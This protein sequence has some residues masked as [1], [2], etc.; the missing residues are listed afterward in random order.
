MDL[1]AAYLALGRQADAA[2]VYDDVLRRRPR[3]TGALKLAGDLARARGDVKTAATNYARLHVLAPHDPRPVF[4]MAAAYVQAGDLERAQRWFDEASQLPGMMGDAY[5][6]LGAIALRR[7]DA[8]QALWYLSRAVRRRPD[9]A[10]IRYNHAL[11]LHLLGRE[12]E[13]LD[14]LRV[15]A[16]A[17]PG[18]AGVRFFAGVVALALGKLD[19]ATDSFKAAVELD[20]GFDDARE[21]LA[22]LVERRPSPAP[23]DPLSVP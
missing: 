10:T 2:G 11:A 5:A 3:H 9:R 4:L 21:N 22:L 12:A 17:D 14:E 8:R 16:D 7:G 19:E 15:A 18:D 20:P 6:N 23:D 13:A 1:G